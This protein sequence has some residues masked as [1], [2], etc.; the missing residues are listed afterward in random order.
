MHQYRLG[1]DLLE[2]SSVEENLEVQVDNRLSMG[3]QCACVTKKANGILWC[4]KKS[5][6]SMSMEVILSLYS[7]LVRPHLDHCIQFWAP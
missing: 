7:A 2:S 4:I 6:A 5:V 3:K 1:D